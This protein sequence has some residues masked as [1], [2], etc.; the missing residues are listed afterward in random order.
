VT[1][2]G[3]GITNR[4]FKVVHP[5]IARTPAAAGAVDIYSS[6]QQA[7][8]MGGHKDATG[9]PVKGLSLLHAKAADSQSPVTAYTPSSH[10]MPSQTPPSTIV[11]VRK[12]G[13]DTDRFIDRRKELAATTQLNLGGFG[14]QILG[15]FRNGRVEAWL[16]ART[17]DAPSVAVPV[18]V[19]QIAE[20][21]AEFHAVPVVLEDRS[22]QMWH[23]IRGWCAVAPDLSS[24]LTLSSD[25]LIRWQCTRRCRALRGRKQ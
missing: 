15:T 10:P 14:A 20:R 22:P 12:F 7:L 1:P 5:S 21:V 18:V 11:V 23:T 6:P 16:E 9:K 25:C 19:R 24:L 8:E 4:L 13:D 3:G 17:L 2:V